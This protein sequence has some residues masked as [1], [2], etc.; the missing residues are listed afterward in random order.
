MCNQLQLTSFPGDCISFPNTI[1]SMCITS[2][3]LFQVPT[4][5]LSLACVYLVTGIETSLELDSRGGLLQ[6]TKANPVNIADKSYKTLTKRNK[7]EVMWRTFFRY[8]HRNR[9][10]DC[11]NGHRF[12][13]EASACFHFQRRKRT[14]MTFLTPR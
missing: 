2:T 12:P 6:Q 10:A 3:K 9:P 11:G 1:G 4:V 14:G 7:S 8:I 13:Y 5:L